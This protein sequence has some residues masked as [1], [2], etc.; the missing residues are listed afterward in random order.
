MKFYLFFLLQLFLPFL[1][2]AQSTVK[3][4]GTTKT[5]ENIALSNA[6]V[7]F[8]N[9]SNKNLS[10]R[11][12]TQKDGTFYVSIP[13]GSY[14]LE[15][16]YVGYVSYFT[17]VN[18][19]DKIVLPDIVLGT[20]SKLMKEVVV[21]AKSITFNPT[22]YIANIAMN[23]FY[24]NYDLDDI[25]KLT[26]G[27]NTTIR[28]ITVNGK[29]ISKIYINNREIHLSGEELIYYLKNYN[30]KNVKQME[31]I[32]SAGAENDASSMGG[33]IIKIT[34]NSV[35]DGGRLS[36]Y[37]MS[38]N[39]KSS[40]FLTPGVNVEWRK[41]KWSVYYIG[42]AM[43]HGTSNT[44][45][46]NYTLFYSTGNA[47][48]TYNRSHYNIPHNYYSNLGFGYDF[49]QNNLLTFE[50]FF[51]DNRFNNNSATQTYQNTAQTNVSQ[52]MTTG[53]MS[54]TG[55]GKQNSL[56]MNYTHFFNKKSQIIFKLD[57]LQ[58]NTDNNQTN[59]FQY[60]AIGNNTEVNNQNTERNLIYT[61]SSDFENSN[62]NGNKLTAGIKYSY[63]NDKSNTDYKYY[64]NNI[65][66]NTHSYID[67]YKYNE[68][69]YAMYGKYNLSYKKFSS[70]FGFRIEHSILSPQ[71]YINTNNNHTSHYTDFFPEI[72]IQYNINK[73][74]GHSISINYTRS[75]QRPRMEDLNPLIK[76]V[77][78]YLYTTG[79][80]YLKPVYCNNFQISSI[81][82]NKYTLHV[83]YRHYTDEVIP[84][85]TTGTE[86]PEVVY[87]QPQN[88]LDWK[89][90]N[91]Y[92]EI[93][94]IIQRFANIKFSGRYNIGHEKY[95][96][97]ESNSQSWGTS[98]SAMFRLPY[99]F[100]V[101][102]NISYSRTIHSLYSKYIE[103]PTIFFNINKSFLKKRLMASVL[104]NDIL[105][106]DGS[107]QTKSYYDTYYQ[108]TKNT[109]NNFIIGFSLRY[110][111][112]WGNN[113]AKINRNDAGSLNE[114]GRLTTN[115]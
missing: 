33:A 92:L 100:N 28:D 35:E 107:K 76:Q 96:S 66:D 63:I 60:T 11:T 14:L 36:S 77:N 4:S 93:P 97:D 74:K 106:S 70:A 56:S 53:L 87:T 112:N 89:S 22:G 58:R 17:T 55:T 109:Y 65:P 98:M 79:N 104:F 31:V 29:I 12:T 5:T 108:N 16:S 114:Q 24:K 72:D 59:S 1:L 10:F 23:P 102:A 99:Q 90:L 46:E 25:L 115:P 84:I 51:R 2:Q 64:A 103:C 48:T 94:V 40:H 62:S 69:V 110:S 81:L 91:V 95:Q 9:I 52:Q 105:K 54:N 88:G 3:I 30:G 7:R 39:G 20:E 85:G 78:E 67:L 101:M 6:N 19:T 43:L 18:A 47:N 80:P 42:S 73:D 113:Q 27:T 15:I 32:S 45:D 26:P 68:Q 8:E 44:T 37:M 13:R 82:F 41:G 34:T 38:N 21:T 71:S 61:A 49:N 50:G 111:L 75:I 57:R 86:N 83:D